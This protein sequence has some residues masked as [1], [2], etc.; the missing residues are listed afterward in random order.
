MAAFMIGCRE[1]PQDWS[2]TKELTAQ[3]QAMIL[4]EVLERYFQVH[5]KYPGELNELIPQHIDAIPRPNIG[6]NEWEYF[7]SPKGTHYNLKVASREA[8]PF[9][10]YMIS[11]K[12]FYHKYKF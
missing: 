7:P 4:A 2:K 6:S 10:V 5:G 1:F 11:E 8:I 12:R 9:L 3:G